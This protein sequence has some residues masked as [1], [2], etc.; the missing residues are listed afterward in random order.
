LADLLVKLEEKGPRAI[1][2]DVLLDQ[3][4]EPEKDRLLAKTIRE[5]K[6]PLFISYSN[7]PGIVNEEQ[8]AYLNDFVPPNLRRCQ[9]RS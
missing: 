7:T 5:I 2:L 6:T 4:T 9:S 3:A 1:A 8:L